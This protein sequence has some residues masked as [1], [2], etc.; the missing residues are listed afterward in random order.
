MLNNASKT[1]KFFYRDRD[2][3]YPFWRL[4][5]PEEHEMETKIKSKEA[6]KYIFNCLEDMGQVNVPTDLERG[7]LLAEKVD[8]REFIDLLKRMLTM[9]QVIFR[10]SRIF[11]LF[12]FP[13][14]YYFIIAIWFAFTNF[15]SI[16]GEK[17]YTK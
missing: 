12:I 3:S 5:T 1:T 10:I 15:F 13:N 17:N 6:R 14:F 4:K 8:R 11:N 7:E 16:I 9:D 2:S